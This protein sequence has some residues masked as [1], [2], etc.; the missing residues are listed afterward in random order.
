MYYYELADERFE[1]AETKVFNW[2]SVSC[3]SQRI[4]LISG[5]FRET[6]S[7]TVPSQPMKW[8]KIKC[9]AETPLLKQPWLSMFL[10]TSAL[11]MDFWATVLR[12]KLVLRPSTTCESGL[13]ILYH[14]QI[15]Q[16]ALIPIPPAVWQKIFLKAL[17]QNHPKSRSERQKDPKTTLQRVKTSSLK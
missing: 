9:V 2:K 5:L 13:Y 8:G 4:H 3:F 6:L 14:L 1:L 15:H 11:W 16:I 10:L 17:S 7:Y 12:V